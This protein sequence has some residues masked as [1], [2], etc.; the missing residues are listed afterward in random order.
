MQRLR[1]YRFIVPA[2]VLLALGIAAMLL[3]GRSVLVGQALDD[4]RS[5]WAQRA[6]DRYQLAVMQQTERGICQQE[7]SADNERSGVAQ[8]NSCGQ[9][10]TWTVTRLFNWIAE[11]E[12]SSA[13]CYP[14]ESLCACRASIRTAV[15]YDEQQGYPSEIFYEWR[16]LP[17][18]TSPDYYRLLFDQTFPGCDKD[19][20]GG[21][22][23]M[24]ISLSPEP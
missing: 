12:R 1:Q 3:F 4:A 18:L 8:F 22:V 17:N 6:F 23:L 20:T 19:G 14:S 5:R 13:V 16:K 9:P 15:V 2:A 11:L 7:I 10:A 24:Q 21:P